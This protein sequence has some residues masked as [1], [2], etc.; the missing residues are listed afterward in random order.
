MTEVQTDRSTEINVK[1][2]WAEEV[3]SKSQALF[4]GILDIADEAIISIDDA[5]RILLF[6][7]GAARIFGYAPE[8]AIGQPLDLLLPK[9]FVAVHRRHVVDFAASAVTARLIGERQKIFGRRKDGEEFPAEASISKLDIDG[10]RIFTVMLRDVTESKQAEAE[11]EKLIAELKALSEAAQGITSELSLE[12]VLQKITQAA[13]TLIKVKYTALGIHDGH[14][15]LSQFIT[16]GISQAGHAKIGPLPTGRGLLGL[17]LR[18]GQSLIINDVAHHPASAGFPAHHPTMRSLLGVPI[19][20]KGELIGALYL[21][22]KEDGSDFREADRQVIETLALHAAI[23]IDNARLYEKIQRLA[24]LEERERFARDLHDGII[25]S[26]YAA[27]L[28]LDIIKADIP[29]ANQHVRE[30]IELSLKS[31][32]NVITDIRNY[33]FDLRPQA[34]R[35]KGLKARLEGLVKELQVNT[36]LAIRA[37]VSPDI[38]AYLAE[39]QASHVFHICHEAL[40]NAARHAKA[41]HIYLS[42]T[43]KEEIITLRVEDDG[44]GFEAPP[45]INPGHHGLANIQARVS[46]LGATLKIESAPQQGTRLTMTL[47]VRPTR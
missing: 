18:G 22:D 14:G 32:A 39:S 6:N 16:A 30:Q 35:G 37:E 9:R 41:R 8:E 1:P 23:A 25:Q 3:G 27:G 31:L 21:A 34:L 19:F 2:P 10:Q 45:E 7:Q 24:I 12:P 5:Q 17:M 42:L 36:T 33:I 11:R 26:I 29:P 46:Q 40:A 20:S 4:A 15:H 44:I 47:N 43:R 28:S 13:Q 38:N